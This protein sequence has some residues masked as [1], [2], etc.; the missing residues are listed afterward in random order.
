MVI[1]Y[2]GPLT[3]INTFDEVA[4]AVAAFAAVVV[5]F[6]WIADSY[7]RLAECRSPA[8]RVASLLLAPDQIDGKSHATS[9]DSSS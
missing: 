8:N 2:Q 4:P 5:A 3:C 1:F 9:I 6:S 7:G